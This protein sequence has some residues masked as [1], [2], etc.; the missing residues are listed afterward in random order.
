VYELVYNVQPISTV[1]LM[2][3]GN[4]GTDVRGAE[5]TWCY[6][7]Y[8]HTVGDLY[9][10]KVR[11]HGTQHDIAYNTVTAKWEVYETDDYPSSISHIGNTVTGFL[12]SGAIMF[13]WSDPYASQSQGTP[14]WAQR[15]SQLEGKASND[16]FASSL[17]LSDDGARLVVG[18]THADWVEDG[19]TRHDAGNV[20]VY[21]YKESSDSAITIRQ[22]GAD[23]DGEVAGGYSGWSIAMSSDGTVMAVGAPYDDGSALDTGRVRVHQW[24]G[25]SR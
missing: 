14:E 2:V 12:N 23:I 7:D 11:D 17:A 20:Y 8:R 25:G 24:S 19:T 5:C 15:G 18:A 22:L 13:E 21:D 9:I 1:G 3:A 4:F 6:Y 16:Y 10:Y